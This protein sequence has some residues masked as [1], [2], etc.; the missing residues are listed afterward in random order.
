MWPIILN[1]VRIYAPYIVWPAAAVVGFVGYHLETGIR[2]E[3]GMHTP[4]KDHSIIDEREERHLKENQNKD[5]TEVDALKDRKFVSK[6][7][8]KPQKEEH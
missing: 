4:A 5:L 1:A 3:E 6:L 2:G 7:I 8:Q